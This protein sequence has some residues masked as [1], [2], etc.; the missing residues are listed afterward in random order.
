MAEQKCARCDYPRTR[1]RALHLWSARRRFM[2][3]ACLAEFADW[4][5]SPSVRFSESPLPPVDDAPYTS[6]EFNEAGDM[7]MVDPDTNEMERD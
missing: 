7:V 5:V 3:S 6:F 4:Y 2:C 1:P